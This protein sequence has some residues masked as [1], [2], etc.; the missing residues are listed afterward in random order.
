MTGGTGYIGKRLK[1]AHIGKGYEVYI[2]SRKG[3]ESKLRMVLSPSSQTRSTTPVFNI[4]FLRVAYLSKLMEWPTLH[5][6]KLR[7]S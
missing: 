1:S 7:F 6:Q 5:R 2:L 4:K 3:S